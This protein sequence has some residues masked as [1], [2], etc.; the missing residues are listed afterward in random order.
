[1]NL[2]RSRQLFEAAKQLISAG[3]NSPARAF[4]SVSV[5]PPFI[6]EG[7]GSRIIDVDDNSDMDIV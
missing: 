1:M 6:R 2:Q 5:N 7:K 4:R 3:V